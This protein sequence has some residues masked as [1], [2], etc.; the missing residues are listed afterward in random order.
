[1]S[2]VTWGDNTRTWQNSGQTPKI[3]YSTP[4]P[5]FSIHTQNHL[6]I[7]KNWCLF[8][9]FLKNHS[10]FPLS[11]PHPILNHYLQQR[12][13]MNQTQLTIRVHLTLL[14]IFHTCCLPTCF[15]TCSLGPRVVISI[16]LSST[17]LFLSLQSF[18]ILSLCSHPTDSFLVNRYHKIF[19][20]GLKRRKFHKKFGFPTR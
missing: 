8:V 7:F 13:P 6:P 18:P 14:A 20:I 9:G 2:L 12:E 17:F 4:S 15:T 3:I 10:H 5:P 16:N 11:S 1:M 19:I